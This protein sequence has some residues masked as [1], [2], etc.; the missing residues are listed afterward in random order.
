[1]ALYEPWVV[2]IGPTHVR[3]CTSQA[4][5][6]LVLFY[7]TVSVGLLLHVRYGRVRF[8]S[9]GTVLRDWPGRMSLK[10]PVIVS[11]GASSLVSVGVSCLQV[12]DWLEAGNERDA[13][14][15]EEGAAA[16]YPPR[17]EAHRRQDHTGR[18]VL[19]L[20]HPT[21]RCVT[22]QMPACSSFP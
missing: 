9:F 21:W 15:S 3:H 18:V 13:E 11:S 17:S 10:W 6:A 14:E 16:S 12:R 5:L 4:N 7:V 8:S 19:Q 20:L 2:R 22:W 1:M